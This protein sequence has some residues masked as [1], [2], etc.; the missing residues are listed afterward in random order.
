M[1]QF[2]VADRLKMSVAELR[3]MSVSEFYG[4]IAYLKIE[5]DREKK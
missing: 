2:I 1:A 4:W 3:R 5:R